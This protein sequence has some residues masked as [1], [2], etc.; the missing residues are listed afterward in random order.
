VRNFALGVSFQ[1]AIL[2]L[3]I[4][5]YRKLEAYATFDSNSSEKR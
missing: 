1:L 2:Q 5:D 4:F 3:V